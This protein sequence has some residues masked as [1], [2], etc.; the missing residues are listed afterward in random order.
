MPI[1]NVIDLDQNIENRN[2]DIIFTSSVLKP[3]DENILD[4]QSII[5]REIENASLYTLR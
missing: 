4:V 1:E 2:N 5:E 3:I